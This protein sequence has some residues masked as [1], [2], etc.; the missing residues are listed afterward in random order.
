MDPSGS[1]LRDA[2]SLVES[3]ISNDALLHQISQIL[4]HRTG[5]ALC[6]NRWQEHGLRRQYNARLPR[7]RWLSRCT[8]SGS[9]IRARW[10]CS[11]HCGRVVVLDIVPDDDYRVGRGW[12][13]GSRSGS[14][15]VIVGGGWW[16]MKLE[17]WMEWGVL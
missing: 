15:V 13:W 8:G 14:A 10:R 6:A 1:G 11:S 12:G 3:R 17:E 5:T 7:P 4:G 9:P 2:E 16:I